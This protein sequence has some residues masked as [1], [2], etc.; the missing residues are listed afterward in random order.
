MPVARLSSAL[1]VHMSQNLCLSGTSVQCEFMSVCLS[2]CSCSTYHLLA[3]LFTCLSVCKFLLYVCRSVCLSASLNCMSACLPVCLSDSVC[4]SES[5]NACL[6]VCLSVRL[7]DFVC[8][9]VCKF[10]VHVCM[11]VCLSV[12][13]SVCMTDVVCLHD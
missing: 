7:K 6:L 9:T 8:L 11:S 3:W 2:T 10:K 12:C 13:V 1:Y 5:S 4:L